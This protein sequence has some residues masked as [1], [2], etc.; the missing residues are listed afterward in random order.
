MGRKQSRAQRA[1]RAY[2]P[3]HVSLSRSR[4]CAIYPANMALREP[5]F[6]PGKNAY[7]CTLAAEMLSRNTHAHTHIYMGHWRVMRSTD[8]CGLAARVQHVYTPIWRA[9]FRL[10]AQM[11]QHLHCVPLTHRFRVFFLPD[12]EKVASER[13]C[14]S[15]T[16]ADYSLWSIICGFTLLAVGRARTLWNVSQISYTV[17]I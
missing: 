2:T 14:T 9:R 13:V 12:S 7:N 11:R 8:D 17:S 10:R 1:L 6:R 16:R 15:R 5:V 3:I 4:F